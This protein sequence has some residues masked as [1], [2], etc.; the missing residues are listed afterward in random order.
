MG[1]CKRYCT[2]PGNTVLESLYRDI[3]IYRRSQD[4]A[5]YTYTVVPSNASGTGPSAN[6]NKVIAGNAKS[7]PYS[8][9]FDTADA[10]DIYT[11]FSNIG[12]TR[13][14]AYYSSKKLVQYWGGTKADEW[15]ITPKFDLKAG[16]NYKLTFDTYLESATSANEKDLR[17]TLGQGVTVEQQSQLLDS[18]HLDYALP[19]TIEIIFYVENDGNWNIG[20]NCFGKSSSYAISSTI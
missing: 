17:I 19:R 13:T 9:T 12:N 2:N 16:K 5:A 14:W 1:G 7:I 15:L 11:I 6:S 8:E 4:L 10:L 3:A 18:I 20:F